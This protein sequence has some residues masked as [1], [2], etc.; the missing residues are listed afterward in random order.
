MPTNAKI[1]NVK[2]KKQQSEQNLIKCDSS[3]NVLTISFNQC[4]NQNKS[5]S[6]IEKQSNTLSNEF[7]NGKKLNKNYK[8]STIVTNLPY[9]IKSEDGNHTVINV[10]EASQF[11]FIINERKCKYLINEN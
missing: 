11:Q 5:L 1:L 8:D 10:K 4:L 9:L 7:F 3:K 2:C 6:D